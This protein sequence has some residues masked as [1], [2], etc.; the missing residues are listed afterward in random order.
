MVELVAAVRGNVEIFKAVVVI[1]ADGDAHAVAEALQTSFLGH[2]FEGAIGFLVE[3]AVPVSWTGLLG[4]GALRRGIL[5]G[6]A[7][8][9]ENVEAA[10]VVVIKEGNTA[11]HGFHQIVLGRMRRQVIE[12]DA[13][14][15][16]NVSE[17]PWQWLL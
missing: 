4:D 1:I 15:G 16:C 8:N 12:V 2:V 14:E 6:G 7:V 11:T 13:E 3:E 10:V 9:E 17:F 5:E